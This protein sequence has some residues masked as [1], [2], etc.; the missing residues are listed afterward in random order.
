MKIEC[1]LERPEP[2]V[3]PIGNEKYE[4]EPD[5]H[6][7]R[8]AEVWIE[9]HIEAFL[10]VDYLYREVKEPEAVTPTMPKPAKGKKA[11]GAA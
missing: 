9:S 5:E 7:R 11:A 2:I 1:M 4:F 3:I 6:G 8:V 10:A